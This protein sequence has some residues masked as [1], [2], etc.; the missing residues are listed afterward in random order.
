VTKQDAQAVLHANDRG[1]QVIATT[2]AASEDEVASSPLLSIL[3]G[4]RREAAVSDTVAKKNGGRKFV[5][6]RCADPAFQTLYDVRKK[7]V[8]HTAHVVDK[9]LAV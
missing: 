8:S 4:G 6:E 7:K 2:H 9:A 5:V 3:N 1:V